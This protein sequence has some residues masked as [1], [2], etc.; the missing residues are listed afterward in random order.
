MP[1][2]RVLQAVG[3]HYLGQKFAR[4]FDIKVTIV[5]FVA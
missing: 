2:G 5:D 3:A 4:V 1:C